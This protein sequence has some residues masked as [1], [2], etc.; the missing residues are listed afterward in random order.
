MTIASISM[1]E[2]LLAR[3]DS[4]ADE[5]GYSGRSEVVREGTRTLLEEFQRREIDG[6]LHICTVI[7]IFEYCQLTVQQRLRGIRHE[8]DSTVSATTHAHVGEQYCIELFVLEGS[9]EEISGF[10][11]TVRSVSDVR[12]VDYSITSLAEDLPD[13]SIQ[14]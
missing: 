9:V 13:H 14:S 10:V 6:Q 8:N 11:N 12:A 2:A 4:F 7:V 5:H 3:I 1:S